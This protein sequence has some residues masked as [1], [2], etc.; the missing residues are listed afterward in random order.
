MVQPNP[1]HTRRRVSDYRA[2]LRAQGLKPLQIW[3]PDVRSRTFL[4]QAHLQSIAVARSGTADEDQAFID[5]VA[6]WGD[7]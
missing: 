4:E 5:A 2:R 3:V 1:Q 6:D 7:E